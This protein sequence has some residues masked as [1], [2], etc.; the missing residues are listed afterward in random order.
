MVYMFENK[1]L[2]QLDEKKGHWTKVNILI[3]EPCEAIIRIII[4]T[5]SSTKSVSTTV[6]FQTQKS[7]HFIVLPSKIFYHT[8]ERLTSFFFW[9]E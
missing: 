5:E 7:K 3:F 9:Y 4:Q 6:H 8:K 1:I 2:F